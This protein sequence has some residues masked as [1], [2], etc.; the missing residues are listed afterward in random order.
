[1]ILRRV[2]WSILLAA[3]L[4][5]MVFRMEISRF[6]S[7][8]DALLAAGMILAVLGGVGILLEL[9]FNKEKEKEHA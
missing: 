4:L 5:L 8:I 7:D 2:K 3:G 6:C 9:Y 1:M